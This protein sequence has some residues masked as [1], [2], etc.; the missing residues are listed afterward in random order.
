MLIQTSNILNEKHRMENSLMLVFS[1]WQTLMYLILNNHQRKVKKLK[2]INNLYSYLNHR[3][4]PLLENK[5]TT[6]LKNKLGYS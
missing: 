6:F 1:C 2:I 3:Y 5:K 4:I